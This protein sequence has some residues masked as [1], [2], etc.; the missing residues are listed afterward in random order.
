[1]AFGAELL[2]FLNTSFKTYPAY[3]PQLLDSRGCPNSA[4]EVVLIVK[5]SKQEVRP[6]NSPSQ[7]LFV[8]W[9]PNKP[10]TKATSFLPSICHVFP[11]IDMLHDP[12]SAILVMAPTS[13]MYTA[14][15]A[16]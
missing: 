4:L 14:C 11:D 3:S 9:D 2:K 7:A 13:W 8:S 6:L 1:M 10:R 12:S 5:P 16:T 15:I